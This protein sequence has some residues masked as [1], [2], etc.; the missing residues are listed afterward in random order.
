MFLL[1]KLLRKK[2]LEKSPWMQYYGNEAENFKFTDKTIYEFLKSRIPDEYTDSIALN[3][4]GRKFTYGEMFRKVDQISKSLLSLGVTKG[5]VVTICM[6]NTPEAIISFYAVNNIG[7]IA[8][9]VHPL[10]ASEE[11]KSYLKESDSKIMIMID[12]DYEK[13]K[14][15][16]DS[17]MMNKIILVS[18]KDSMPKL[19]KVGYQITRG[20]K[21]KKP[22]LT[23]RLYIG[24]GEFVF[25]GMLYKEPIENKMDSKDV[26]VILH[27]GGTTGV[28]KGI[29]LSNYNFNAEV[30]QCMFYVNKVTIGEKMLTVLPIF[31]GFG[32]AVCIHGPLCLG[33]E[34]ILM[35]EFNPKTFIK[36]IVE[37]K[38]NVLAGVPSMWEVMMNA[39]ELEDFDL[40]FLK[41]VISG[42]DS[43]SEA[44]ENKINNFLR[45]HGATICIGKG[46][47]MT[48]SVAA[49]CL[50]LEGG[51]PGSVG[52]P[53]IQN[54]YCIC[55]PNSQEVLD[56]GCEG[57]ICVSGPT[58]MIGYLNNEKETNMVLQR[59]EDGNIW[60]HT[61]D[62]GYIAPD[63]YVYFTQRLKRMII[64]NG[65]NVYPSQIEE[66]IERHPK[67]LK[68]SVVGIPHPKKVQVAKAFIVL[69]SDSKVTSKIKKEIKELC[70]KNLARYSLPKEYEFRESLPKTL[71]GK[72]NYR[73]LEKEEYNEK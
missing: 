70:E 33:L 14:D 1:D 44:L 19:L 61:G 51:K 62:L 48:E 43:L 5:D 66:V 21:I 38:P 73:E 22:K 16:I 36:I 34:T 47:G 45:S 20:Y 10:S 52:L 8:N 71:L 67:V 9:M 41:Y 65:F 59:H 63:G 39:K 11:I 54:N 27:S 6:P 25:S 24:W 58:V 28:P 26:A 50:T 64:S 2:N 32:L 46:Y 3:Y 42:G 56:F 57:E 4:F 12:F 68:C 17:S 72:V 7:A 29:L 30:E 40:S 15:T 31:H 23:N 69:K 37:D 49:T 35:P 60:L 13:I 53:M 18:A 55:I